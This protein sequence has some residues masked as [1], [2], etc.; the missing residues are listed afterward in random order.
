[1]YGVGIKYSDSSAR[2]EYILLKS[3]DKDKWLEKY[4]KRVPTVAAR[5]ILSKFQNDLVRIKTT[6]MAA[7]ITELKNKIQSEE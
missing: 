1:M 6:V 7:D 3:A 2:Q 5:T 4:F